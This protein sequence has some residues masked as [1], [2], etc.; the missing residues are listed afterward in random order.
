MTAC[1]ERGVELEVPIKG[2]EFLGKPK[3]SAFQRKT[4]LHGVKYLLYTSEFVGLF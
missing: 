1:C 3:L 2:R 4:L